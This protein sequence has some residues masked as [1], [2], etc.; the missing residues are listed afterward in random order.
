MNKCRVTQDVVLSLATPI[1]GV[2]GQEMSEIPIPKGTDIIM[3]I[4]GCNVSPEIW[5]PDSQEWKPER[6]LESLPASVT[7]ARIPGIY[8]NL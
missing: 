6:W 3:N 4:L 8:S 1:K 7:T 2:D 5:G